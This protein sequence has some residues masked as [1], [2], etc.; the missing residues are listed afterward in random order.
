[1]N[2]MA[3]IMEGLQKM[4]ETNPEVF[5]QAMESLGLPVGEQSS[6]FDEEDSL[7]KMADAIKQMRMDQPGSKDGSDLV[8]SK[9][10][11]KQVSLHVNLF[12]LIHAKAI[13]LTNLHILY[14]CTHL[15]AKG[16]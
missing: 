7:A 13:H 10:A 12:V 14:Y 6:I 4:K 11:P 9:D 1:M 2:D 8:M 3:T 5:K 15:T 16:N